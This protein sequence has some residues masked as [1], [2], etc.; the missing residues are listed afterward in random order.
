MHTEQERCQRGHVEDNEVITGLLD[1]R[2]NCCVWNLTDIFT[3]SHEAVKTVPCNL[4]AVR[5]L[6]G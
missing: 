3:V 2:R 1:S 6:K 5:D 4:S